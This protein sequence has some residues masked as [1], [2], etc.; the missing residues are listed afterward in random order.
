MICK[1]CAAGDAHLLA[2]I[3]ARPVNETDFGIPADR[4]SREIYS[5]NSCNVYFSVH[6]FDFNEIYLGKYNSSTYNDRLPQQFSRIMSLPFDRSDNR[7]RA[8]RVH[9]FMA[10]RGYSPE[11]CEVLDVGSGLCVFLAAMREYGYS[12]NCVDPDEGSIWLAR[13]SAGVKEA[14]QGGIGDVPLTRRYHL[15]TLNKVL[16][17][18]EA[19]ADMLQ[20]AVDRLT[21]GGIC[22]IE[23]PDGENAL[24]NGNIVDREEFY[25]EHYFVFSLKSTAYLLNQVNLKIHDLK[26]IL[27]PSGKYTV[28]AFA[29][30]I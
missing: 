16:E 4:Y 8:K 21:P 1:L 19:P 23:L 11:G 3:T 25:I 13:E 20:Q 9:E 27:E 7:H 17:H 24:K 2:T 5:C 29:E 18:V 12:G 22:Y 26:A 10:G 6:S 28:Y 15:I 30:K 14:F